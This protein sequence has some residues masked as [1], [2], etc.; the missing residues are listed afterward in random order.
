MTD[1]R[2]LMGD[3]W[4]EARARTLIEEMA[5]KDGEE[6]VIDGGQALSGIAHWQPGT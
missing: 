5:T 1:C 6:L 3:E 2:M 4:D